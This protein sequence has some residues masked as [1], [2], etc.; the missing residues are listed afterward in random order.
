VSVSSGSHETLGGKVTAIPLGC[1]LLT[2]VGAGWFPFNAMLRREKA[3]PGTPKKPRRLTGLDSD[4]LAS[5]PFIPDFP[6]R[7]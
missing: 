6:D 3:P 5:S 4:M 1:L 2:I 7:R